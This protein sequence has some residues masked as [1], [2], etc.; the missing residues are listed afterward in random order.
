MDWAALLG[1]AL[2]AIAS[3]VGVLYS[4]RATRKL[5]MYRVDQ[6]EKKVEIHNT[7]DRR[8]VAIETKLGMISGGK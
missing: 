4:N 5:V 6:L 3:L 1:A 8:M 7:F 2:T